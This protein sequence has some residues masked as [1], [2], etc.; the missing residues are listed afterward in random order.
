MLYHWHGFHALRLLV[1]R[2]RTEASMVWKASVVE[3][4]NDTLETLNL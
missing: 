4:F 2:W 1:G 3:A